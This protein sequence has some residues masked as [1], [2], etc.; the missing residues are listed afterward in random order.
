MASS[1]FPFR[2]LF[3]VLN[4]S[5]EINFL[6]HYSLFTSLELFT[7]FSMHLAMLV[8]NVAFFLLSQPFLPHSLWSFLRNI[9]I[10]LS[11]VRLS[12]LGTAA[13]TGLLYQPKLIDDECGA[14]GG[15]KIGRAKRSTRH[16]PAPV[17]L[18]P[19]Q[20]PRDQIRTGT[21]A[22]AVGNRR[23]TAWAMAR[24]YL[25]VSLNEFTALAL[26]CHFLCIIPWNAESFLLRLALCGPI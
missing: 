2:F 5:K 12:P 22:A 24:P 10:I 7:Q 21:R 6:P 25:K 15:M 4:C 20:I 23:L 3:G 17:P 18:F 1:C 26:S 11:G 9:I 19:P 8:E 16:N 13:T 14:I